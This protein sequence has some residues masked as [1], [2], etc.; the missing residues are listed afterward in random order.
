MVDGEVMVD[1]TAKEPACKMVAEWL[2]NV[3]ENIPEE[4]G[5][6]AWRKKSFQWF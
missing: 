1:G 4:I 6:N 3:Y 5:R 2:I